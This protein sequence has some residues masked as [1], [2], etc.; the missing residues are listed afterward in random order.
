MVEDG[1]KADLL[2]AVMR[3]LEVASAS[4]MAEGAMF[5]GCDV[6]RVVD[7]AMEVLADKKW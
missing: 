5:A 1:G 6:G 7:A 4:L 2:D 3:P